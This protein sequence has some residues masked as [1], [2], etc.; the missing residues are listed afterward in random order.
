MIFALIP[1]GQRFLGKFARKI[2]LNER[3]N[4][5]ESIGVKKARYKNK[6]KSPA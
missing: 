6:R 2:V 1:S 3:K 5:S 4:D